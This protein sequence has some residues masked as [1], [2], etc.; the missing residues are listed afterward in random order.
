MSETATTPAVGLKALIEQRA[1]LDALI[2]EEQSLHKSENVRKVRAFIR[3]HGLTV[4]DVFPGQSKSPKVAALRKARTTLPVKFRDPGNAEHTWTGRGFKPKWLA[5]ALANGHTIEEF[6][7]DKP[8]TPAPAAP[9]A[10]KSAAKK[11]GS[12]KTDTP[13]GEEF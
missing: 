3:D 1:R 11:G 5:Y 2:A 10:K 4:D 7:V 9:A 13:S 8:A 12:K 6:A